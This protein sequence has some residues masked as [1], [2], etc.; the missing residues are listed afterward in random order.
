V[1]TI[2]QLI[3]VPFEDLFKVIQ[4][5]PDAVVGYAVL[6][7]VVGANLLAAIAGADLLLSCGG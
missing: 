7:E 1:Q 3:Q 4:S 2:D 6:R 5:K